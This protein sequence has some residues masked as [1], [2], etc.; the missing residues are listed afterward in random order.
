[1]SDS[2]HRVDRVHDAF[3]ALKYIEARAYDMALVDLQM[4][5]MDRFSFLARMQETRPETSVIIMTGHGDMDMAI[6]A[7][8][9]GAGDFLTKPI[10]LLELD[11]VLEKS[12]RIHRLVAQCTQMEEALQESERRYR[13]L[14]ENMTDVVWMT[15]MNLQSTYV[16]PAV[17]RMLGCNAEE[18]MALT[19]EEILTPI[20]FE[21]IKRVIAEELAEES[22]TQRD[23]S[24]SWNIE[25]ELTGRDGSTVW[26]ETKCAFLRDPDGRP[27]GVLGILRD[28]TER[29]KTPEVS[30]DQLQ[31]SVTR[32]GE[33]DGSSSSY[34]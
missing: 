22:M 18:A 19:W 33:T 1:L 20:S 7:L 14:A 15:D 12:V 10:R 27:V 8:K 25:I 31:D 6:R 29:R 4:P 17:T 21:A 24:R 3:A 2:G 32:G 11:A 5:G 26:A 23:L 9:V 16:N 30:G 34:H 13:L 28:I